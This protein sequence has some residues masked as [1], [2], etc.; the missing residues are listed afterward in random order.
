[1][2]A[3][4]IQGHGQAVAL[5][6]S[7][8]GGHD[9]DDTL[10][11]LPELGREQ[12]LGGVIDDGDEGEPLLGDAGEPAMAAAVEMEQFAE[13]GTRLTALPVAAAGAVLG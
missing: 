12:A 13:T 11:P 9:R 5:E 8:Q 2:G 1:V 4:G 7:A 10:A 3:V 6:D